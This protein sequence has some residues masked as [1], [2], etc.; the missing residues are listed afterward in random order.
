MNRREVIRRSALTALGIGLTPSVLLSLESCSKKE[1]TDTVQRYLSG[2][3]YDVL[4]VIAERILPRTDS[5]GADDAGVAPFV[6]Q[7]FGEYFNEA[8]RQMYEEG[9]DQFM[10]DCEETFG[11]S[12]L[13]LAEGDQMDYL[14]ALDKKGQ[15]DP[16]FSSLRKII[17]WAFFTSEIGMKSMNYLPI[18]GRF[19]GCI[20]ID[21]QE[22][23][24]VGNR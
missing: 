15:D 13:D 24:L 6:D 17:L 18:P 22:K 21:G 8:D 23:N 14:I 19:N 5:P 20:T 1:P 3:K 16:F 2:E 9:L 10:L 11:N 4:W 7:L 12:F